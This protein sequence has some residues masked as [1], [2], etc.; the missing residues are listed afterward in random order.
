MQLHPRLQDYESHIEPWMGYVYTGLLLQDYVVWL[1]QTHNQLH[2]EK[3]YLMTVD[4]IPNH[5]Q[6]R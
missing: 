6:T 4:A 1:S 5:M 2:I 3:E